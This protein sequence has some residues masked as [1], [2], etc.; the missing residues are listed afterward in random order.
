MFFLI[1][2]FSFFSST[3]HTFYHSYDSHKQSSWNIFTAES[4]ESYITKEKK[5]KSTVTIMF[6]CSLVNKAVYIISLNPTETG[7]AP[8]H[9]SHRLY[10]INPD[11]DYELRFS[12][13]ATYLW[14]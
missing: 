2:L 13:L 7:E 4:A 14:W 5:E 8:S 9:I 3:Q 12:T 10:R 11:E 6:P 1:L